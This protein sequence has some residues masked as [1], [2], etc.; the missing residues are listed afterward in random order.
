[1]EGLRREDEACLRAATVFVALTKQCRLMDNDGCDTTGSNNILCQ[2]SPSNDNSA[3]Q[4]Q[5]SSRQTPI[6]TLPRVIPQHRGLPLN[7]KRDHL[8]HVLHLAKQSKQDSRTLSLHLAQQ[9][10]QKETSERLEFLR[11][12]I[13]SIVSIADETIA[14]V[15][16]PLLDHLLSFGGNAL[17]DD[18]LPLIREMLFNETETN[19]LAKWIFVAE[20]VMSYASSARPELWEPTGTA[21]C[22]LRSMAKTL[23][24]TNEIELGRQHAFAHLFKLAMRY[25]QTNVE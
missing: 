7:P 3:S 10:S 8:I 23:R 15:R 21:W 24:S 9:L 22:H 20:L 12:E 1:M 18:L 2:Q 16:F 19:E 13:R 11:N 17:A 6:I 25:E 5:P 14:P 4:P